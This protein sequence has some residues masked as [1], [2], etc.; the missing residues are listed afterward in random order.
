MLT[1]TRSI[2]VLLVEDTEND[3]IF[4]TRL[5]EC[6]PFLNFSV[7]RAE[8]LEAAISLMGTED[9]DV[10]LLDLSL[11]DAK[12]LESFDKI[13]AMDARLPVVVLTDLND[14]ELALLAIES[15]AQ[16]FMSKDHL[17]GQ[18]LYRSLIFAIAR[19][20]KVLGFQAAADT[21]PLT[22]MPNRRH[23]KTWFA[24]SLESTSKSGTEM[25]MAILDL[26]HFKRINDQHGHFFGDAVLRHVGQFLA[27]SIGPRMLA[28]RFGGE[29]FAILM[30]GY[31]LP[32]AVSFIDRTL[33]ELASK[34][35]TAGDLAISVTSSA[36]VINTPPDD[37]WD[38]AYMACD[39][40]LYEAK[41]SG[42][43]RLASKD[44]GRQTAGC[45]KHA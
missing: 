19:Q 42:R 24:E 32:V 37:S 9:F 10:S 6:N 45:L 16:D 36:G 20:Q 29:E 34:K 30:P 18:M 1:N 15:G 13:R 38:A 12:G 11:P 41:T 22:G 7:C 3:A 14:E 8:T 21:D 33:R 17:T 40:L 27:D 43:N 35:V 26:D 25:S 4:V 2:Q 28:A 5:L 39:V 31:S 23:L 44:R